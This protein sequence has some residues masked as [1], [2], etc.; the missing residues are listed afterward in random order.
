[1]QFW[2]GSND[3]EAAVPFLRINAVTKCASETASGT[4]VLSVVVDASSQYHIN[5]RHDSSSES[6]RA[7]DSLKSKVL[8]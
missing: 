8:W 1:M 4:D 5:N 2:P 6:L 7:T 3:G